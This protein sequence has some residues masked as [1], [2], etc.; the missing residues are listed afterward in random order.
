ML[1]CVLTLG[2]LH[3]GT[4]KLLESRQPTAAVGYLDRLDYVSMLSNEVCYVE[5]LEHTMH[6]A[7][8]TGTSMQRILLVELARVSNHL[9]NVA[10]HA[11]DMGVLV[12][13]LWLFEDRECLYDITAHATGARMHACSVTPGGARSSM[14]VS[15]LHDTVDVVSSMSN[16]IDGLTVSVL[17]HRT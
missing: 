10:C 8:S 6:V 3:R 11:G 14:S 16:R 7:C 13:L 12:A 2:L 4:E 17:L 9:L 15:L 5:C 1:G